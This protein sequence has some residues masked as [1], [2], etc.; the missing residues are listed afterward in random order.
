MIAPDLLKPAAE[1]DDMTE[2][3]PL[4]LLA[5]RHDPP[6]DGIEGAKIQHQEEA[7]DRGHPKCGDDERRHGEL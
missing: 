1:I 6:D 3:R 5:K 4:V 7:D 2:R